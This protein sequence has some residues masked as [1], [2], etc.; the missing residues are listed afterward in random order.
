MI[1]VPYLE[2]FIMEDCVINNMKGLRLRCSGICWVGF[3]CCHCC[4]GICVV[5]HTPQS[6]RK[7]ALTPNRS[8]QPPPGAGLCVYCMISR[9]QSLPQGLIFRST[10]V[11]WAVVTPAWGGVSGSREL[12]STK[13]SGTH[14]WVSQ[15]FCLC[16]LSVFIQLSSRWASA[17]SSPMTCTLSIRSAWPVSRPIRAQAGLLSL[18]QRPQGHT[19]YMRGKGPLASESSHYGWNFA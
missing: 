17:L 7:E 12:E 18:S 3:C 1:A 2:S 13:D 19:H 11:T 8:R 6:S 9:H 16:K 10:H 4:H 5:S 14:R 15:G